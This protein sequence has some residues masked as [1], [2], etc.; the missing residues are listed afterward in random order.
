MIFSMHKLAQFLSKLYIICESILYRM[1][2]Y[3]KY[4][5]GFDIQ[6]WKEQI[7]ADLEYFTIDHNIIDYASISNKEEMV[8]F[9]DADHVTDSKNRMS[10]QGAVFTIMSWAICFISTK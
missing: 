3:V 2:G 9:F 5:I 4:T 7:Y 6:Y 1:F 10:I 8:A